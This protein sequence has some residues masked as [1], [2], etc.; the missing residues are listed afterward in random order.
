MR[1]YMQ[2]SIGN[3]GYR[4]NSSTDGRKEKTG[5]SFIIRCGGNIT[6]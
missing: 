2:N 5:E 1:T 6:G 3:S 4:Y